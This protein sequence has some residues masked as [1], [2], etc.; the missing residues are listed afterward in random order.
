MFVTVSIA[1]PADVLAPDALA[2]LVFADDLYSGHE[3]LF[4][5][6]LY[7]DHEALKVLLSSILPLMCSV[8]KVSKTCA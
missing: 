7:S 5:D 8:P 2:K 3:A 4:A 6:D 1:R